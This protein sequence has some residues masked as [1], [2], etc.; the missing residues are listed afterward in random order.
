[1]S[2]AGVRATAGVG[3]LLALFGACAWGTEPDGSVSIGWEWVS[4]PRA[5]GGDARL[6]V[7]VRAGQALS[8][9]SLRPSFPAGVGFWTDRLSVS[10]KGPQEV[11][12]L[13]GQP[14][15]VGAL[16]RDATAVVEFVLRLAPGARGPGSLTIEAIDASGR[17][18]REAMGIPVGPVGT[19]PVLRNGAAEF[20]ADSPPA[21]KP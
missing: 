3:L 10:G 13:P 8:D 20:P 11:Q 17:S 1:M 4:A 9:V 12:P 16:T 14:A 21:E 6:R 18:V 7:T 2:Y 19:D 15:V 5:A